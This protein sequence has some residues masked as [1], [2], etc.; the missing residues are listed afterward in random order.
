MAAGSS[1]S[2]DV[3][4]SSWRPPR[5]CDVYR[6][7]LRL[8]RSLSNRFHHVYTYGEKPDC[9]PWGRDLDL[10][11]E[12]ERTG[13]ELA[14]EALRANERNRVA[15]QH[16]HPPVWKLRSRPPEDWHLPLADEAAGK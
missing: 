2:G 9:S 4:A 5:S 3:A 8:C 10:C 16:K 12:W 14:K 6:A 1:S 13:N 11:H 7:E 15:E